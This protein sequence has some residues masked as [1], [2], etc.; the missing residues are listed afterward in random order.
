[1][2]PIH[3][4]LASGRWVTLSIGEQLANIGSEVSRV[5]HWQEEGDNIEKEKALERALELL[6]LTLADARLGRRTF[7]LTR[8][9]E[10]LCD[11][12]LGAN[13][14]DIP[15]ESLEDYFLPFALRVSR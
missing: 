15:L 14:Y 4:N 8:L 3:K 7:E 10:A 12:F 13:E 2:A 5:I 1:M 9:R 11:V 6:D